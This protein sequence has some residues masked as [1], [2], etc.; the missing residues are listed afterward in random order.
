MKERKKFREIYI[1][2]FIFLLGLLTGLLATYY[3]YKKVTFQK[4]YAL[5]FP[6]LKL[7]M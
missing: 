1:E 5:A 6:N 3:L 7:D 2:V 4:K